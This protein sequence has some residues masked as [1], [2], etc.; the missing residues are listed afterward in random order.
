MAECH[1]PGIRKG[2]NKFLGAVFI[3]S[4]DLYI[5]SIY[6][7][8]GNF[9]TGKLNKNNHDI[10]IIGSGCLLKLS[11]QYPQ[12]IRINCFNRKVYLAIIM[13]MQGNFNLVLSENKQILQWT[14]L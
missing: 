2:N 7:H 5:S 1:K 13:K 10:D 6:V 14:E 8:C 4:V 9:L 3:S 12:N 11:I